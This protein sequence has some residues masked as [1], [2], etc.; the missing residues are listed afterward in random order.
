[1]LLHDHPF[2]D[3]ALR[4]LLA[5]LLALPVGWEREKRSHSAGLRTYPLLSVGICGF[6]LL[7]EGAT[8]G[9]SEQADAIFGVLNGIG[10]VGAGA[11]LRTP[12]ESGGMGTAASLW[13]TG[14]IGMAAA[15][16]NPLVAAAL[17]L[18]SLLA[19]WAPLVTR[20]KS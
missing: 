10:F 13:V 11:I 17:S 12:G 2:L 19:L 5:F 16:G 7:A 20:R 8:W 6:M 9:P 4:L 15:F 14:A 18:M 3:A 1:M